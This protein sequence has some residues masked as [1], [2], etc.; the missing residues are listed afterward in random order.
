MI[1]LALDFGTFCDQ[2]LALQCFQ[3]FVNLGHQV[4]HVTGK[5]NAE[6]S[7]A[8]GL[9]PVTYEFSNDAIK[10]LSDLA[11]VKNVTD[12]L[13][14]V[15]GNRKSY[16]GSLISLNN[17]NKR[18]RL[19]VDHIS[20]YSSIDAIVAIYSALPL[21]SA[22]SLHLLR[23]VPSFLILQAPAIPNYT[24]RWI[25]A[26]QMKDPDV[27][28]Y[29]LNRHFEIANFDDA[30]HTMKLIVGKQRYNDIRG[31]INSKQISLL[32]AWDSKS[33]KRIETDVP[34][35]PCGGIYD[36]SL[37][38]T[39]ARTPPAIDG[40]LVKFLS[41][42]RHHHKYCYFSLGSFAGIPHGK[43]VALLTSLIVGVE[44]LGSS[45]MMI[46]HHPFKD[47]SSVL[48]A[49]LEKNS[50]ILQFDGF[51]P[52]EWIVP[53]M[54]FVVTTG[55]TC[56]NNICLVAKKPT[57]YVP[58]I[59]EQFFWAKNYQYQTNVPYV[60][61]HRDFD[62]LD[63]F[64]IKINSILRRSLKSK[65]VENYLSTVSD[66]MTKNIGPINIAKTVTERIGSSK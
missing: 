48:S 25:F 53:R 20:A 2:K 23:R 12:Y 49:F 3:E 22:L 26:D 41:L 30:K 42:R 1:I 5:E 54:D 40:A 27:P 63:L 29:K 4:I 66:S 55:S 44:R 58:I 14:H 7:K 43:L 37:I 51:L 9:V 59:S 39:F 21:L 35:I 56:L 62:E 61:I 24:V 31:L 45:L 46:F 36:P 57:V 33:L 38:R 47:K 8:A 34:L 19:M 50:H 13:K 28:V 10:K 18:V 17:L 52:H 60:D 6:R 64:Q 65:K 11:G 32:Q 15:F 16:F